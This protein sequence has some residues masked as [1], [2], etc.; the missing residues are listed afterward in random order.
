MRKI[1]N[2]I[3]IQKLIILFFVFLITLNADQK[4]VNE[5][6]KITL[7]MLEPISVIIIGILIGFIVYSVMLPIFKMGEML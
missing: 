1:K 3:T 5:K 6:I 2:Y 7:K 4:I